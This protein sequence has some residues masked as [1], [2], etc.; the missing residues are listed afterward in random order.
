[1]EIKTADMICAEYLLY[2]G[3]T[4]SLAALTKEMEKDRLKQFDSVKIV[5]SIYHHLHNYEIEQYIILWDLLAKRFFSHL[6]NEYLQ[7]SNVLKG[8]L[9]KY[10]LIYCFKSNRKD[11]LIEFFQHYSH[12]ILN[13]SSMGTVAESLRTWFVLPYMEEPEKDAEFY[14]YYTQKWTETLKTTLINF[15][16]TVLHAS[17]LPKLLLLE[18]WFQADAQKELRVQ[19]SIYTSKVDNFEVKMEK[20]EE[21][22]AKLRGIIKDLTFIVHKANLTDHSSPRGSNSSS[23]FEVDEEVEKKRN[24]IKELGQVA[25]R[26]ATTGLTIRSKNVNIVNT[27]H[28]KLAGSDEDPIETCE[29][30]LIYVISEWLRASSTMSVE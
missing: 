15:V 21:R 5:D 9:L 22:L 12:D 24:R 26:A 27:S 23:L 20:Y 8:D 2:R 6:D 10:Y 11:K 28:N 19:L 13:Q 3:Y 16:S 1:M 18:K 29:N 17:P 30:E 7:S 4:Q 25:C 14:N